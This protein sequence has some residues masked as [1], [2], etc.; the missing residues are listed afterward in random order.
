[1]KIIVIDKV[2]DILFEMLQNKG[3]E[4]DDFRNIDAK[5]VE[6]KLAN[7]DGIVIRSKIKLTA[8]ILSKLK[9]LKFIARVGAGM[10]SIDIEFAKKNNIVLINSPEGNRDSVG[11]H[12]VGLILSLLH[13]INIANNE[14]KQG[15]WNRE[16]NKCI[17]LMGKTVGIIGYGN[18]GSAT[19]HRLSGFD[20]NVISYDK[21]KTNYT[22]G[23]TKEVEMD[24]IFEK[25]DI[26]S[27]HVPL[28]H[29]TVYLID[30]EYLS[31]FKKPIFII[32]TARGKIIR[33]SDLIQKINEQKVLGAG[34]DVLEYEDI[35]FNKLNLEQNNILKTIQTLPNVILTP[36]TAGVSYESSIKLAKVTAQKIIEKFISSK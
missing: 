27:L 31:K 13:K 17:E 8:E 6:N 22:D 14:A 9:K 5:D 20:V 3:F 4:V 26:L 18:M 36:H 23:Y 28:Q 35:S 12:A 32:N 15:I 16:A 33:T 19:A 11:E 1:M 7:Y 24:E 2:H 25:T 21:Y 34:L 10:E 29:D 30:N